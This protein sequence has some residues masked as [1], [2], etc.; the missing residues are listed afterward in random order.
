APQRAQHPT[1][2][3]DLCL[4][5]DVEPQWRVGIQAERLEG[6]GVGG[7]WRLR[8]PPGRVGARNGR[9]NSGLDSLVS[10]RLFGL[11]GGPSAKNVGQSTNRRGARLP[12]DRSSGSGTLWSMAGSK[13]GATNGLPSLPLKLAT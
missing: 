3:G 7:V 12:P 13:M 9:S 5:Q 1:L 8:G 4:A 2:R 6:P 11:V 10:I